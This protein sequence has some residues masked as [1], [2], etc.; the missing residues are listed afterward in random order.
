MVAPAAG[1]SGDHQSAVSSLSVQVEALGAAADDLPV[2]ACA[3]RMFGPRLNLTSGRR[4]HERR[5][6][7]ATGPLHRSPSATVKVSV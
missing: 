5:H 4:Q 2:V 3:R 1:A 6:Q 7:S